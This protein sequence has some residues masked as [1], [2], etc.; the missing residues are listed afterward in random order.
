MWNRYK[1]N[2]IIR[3]LIYMDF[4]GPMCGFEDNDSL[5][6]K[7]FP[8]A[9]F[10]SLIVITITVLSFMFGKEIYEK[11]QP[12]VSVNNEFL[13]ESRIYFSQFPIVFHFSTMSGHNV[14]DFTPFLELVTFN[15]E[16]DS[17]NRVSRSYNTMNLRDC[18]EKT[19]KAESEDIQ[20]L[21][22]GAQANLNNSNIFFCIDF[23]E[24]DYFQNENFSADS[25]S[26]NL[27]F[28]LCKTN[29][30]S[31]DSVNTSYD[32]IET[33]YCSGIVNPSLDNYTAFKD[34]E[35]KDIMLSI[36]YINSYVDYNNVTSPVQSY[37]EILNHELS[38]TYLKRSYMRFVRN[39]FNSDNAWLLE[40]I[41][42]YNFI[43]LQ[44]IVPDDMLK[45]DTGIE[46]D[47]IYLL[48]LESPRFRSVI[49]RHYLKIQDL[50]AKI[51]GI[52][53]ALLII[54]KLCSYHYLRFLYIYFIRDMTKE[55]VEN[56]KFAYRP[57]MYSFY[58]NDN[59]NHVKTK[60]T[61]AI[62]NN[63]IHHPNNTNDYSNNKNYIDSQ[64]NNKH[65]TDNITKNNN[66]N[67][68]MN[69][70]MHKRKQNVYIKSNPFT[71][72]SKISDELCNEQNSNLSIEEIHKALD[73]NLNNSF[74]KHNKKSNKT[75]N[76]VKLSSSSI[77]KYI[78]TKDGALSDNNSD[79][80]QIQKDKNEFTNYTNKE[81]EER[82]IT[83]IQKFEFKGPVNIYNNSIIKD[84]TDKN[85]NRVIEKYDVENNPIYSH[86]SEDNDL[87]INDR[88]QSNNNLNNILN[89][90]SNKE[91]LNITFEVK[92]ELTPKTSD[93]MKVRIKNYSSNNSDKESTHRNADDKGINN[94]IKENYNNI[95]NK[96]SKKIKPDTTDKRRRK[97]KS[98]LRKL[99]NNNDNKE[100][101]SKPPIN[102][103]K[104]VNK[105]IEINK[106]EKKQKRSRSKEAKSKFYNNNDNIARNK[107]KFEDNRFISNP[108]FIDN[109]ISEGSKGLFNVERSNL[110]LE[111]NNIHSENN[112]IIEPCSTVKNEYNVNTLAVNT[113]NLKR[114]NMKV[115]IKNFKTKVIQNEFGYFSYL[116]SI[117]CCRKELRNKYES[118]MIVVKHAISF[119]ILTNLLIGYI[120]E[121]TTMMEDRSLN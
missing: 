84:I 26:Y 85:K 120:L 91:E 82:G 21:L 31:D 36:Y 112:R 57:G 48:T 12:I 75:G 34:I 98:R 14:I 6:F 104:K 94:L 105:E 27:G 1:D 102:I 8:G 77:K 23:D 70:S 5:R 35:I 83:N 18:S 114:N 121:E 25:I 15:V 100:K 89:K 106:E 38:E 116:S 66:N 71:F 118:Q 11:Q 63:N 117:I 92:D 44:S 95:F 119:K 69:N 3:N 40:D 88:K 78:I 30:G 108:D 79:I 28:R 50:F 22:K 58:N 56:K 73:Q 87:S 46:K 2:K 41:I 107:R 53:N 72:Q 64:T 99:S 93:N 60:K 33:P 62:I 19:F 52:M 9:I 111:S 7:S 59:I 32:G 113:D 115:N 47:L 61:G 16:M 20:K 42:P 29:D 24:D 97:D 55:T 37:W 109:A 101:E 51:G 110:K 81:R 43:Q 80:S 4:I 67:S 76:L 10:S 54:V 39:Q 17:Q 13:T 103:E 68:F 65:I 49:K 86:D 96:Q 74:Y 45:S 90:Y